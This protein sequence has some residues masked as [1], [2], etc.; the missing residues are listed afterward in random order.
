MSTKEKITAVL[1]VIALLGWMLTSVT[2]IDA[3]LVSL[4]V[5]LVMFITGILAGPDFKNSIAWSC[6][7][8]A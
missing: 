6:S 3:T 4:V 2:G 7:S 5:L 8:F 1:L